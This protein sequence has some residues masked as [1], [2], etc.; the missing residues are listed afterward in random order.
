MS[1]P[2]PPTSTVPRLAWA[3]SVG[4]SMNAIAAFDSAIAAGTD[5]S[6]ASSGFQT[7]LSTYS[8]AASRLASA[9]DA[10]TSAVSSAQGNV[11]SAQQNVNTPSSRSDGYLDQARVARA[12]AE[13]PGKP[14]P[15]DLVTTSASGFDPHITPAAAEFQVPRVAKARAMSEEAVRALVAQHTQGRQWGFFGE[16]RVNVLELNLTLDSLSK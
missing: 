16:P 7:A 3:G 9:I 13:N 11:S 10:P 6:T 14:V 12:Q 15:I 2:T 4:L 5:T 8:Q 1:D